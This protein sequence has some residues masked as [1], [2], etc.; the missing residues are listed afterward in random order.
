MEPDSYD[1][2]DMCLDKNLNDQQLREILDFF[3]NLPYYKEFDIDMG[4]KKQ[5]F[6]VVHGGLVRSCLNKDET[7]SKRSIADSDDEWKKYDCNKN[8]EE[9]IWKR[10]RYGYPWLKKTIV[11][12]GHTTTLSSKATNSGAV[13]GM[14][15]YMH[16]CINVDCGA[17]FRSEGYKK[18]NLAA[19][20]L[21]DLKEFYAYEPIGDTQEIEEK[22]IKMK[23]RL[24]LSHRE[25]AQI[26]RKEQSELRKQDRKFDWDNMF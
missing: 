6:I 24:L 2:H 26:R 25:L 7:F 4:N 22:N 13:P 12:H 18:A 16:K 15:H 19:I 23:A 14:I 21:E 11:V 3:R 20:R 1:F 17:V 9:I 10:D 5:H 8:K